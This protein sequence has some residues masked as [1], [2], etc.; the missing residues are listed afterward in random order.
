MWIHQVHPNTYLKHCFT[1]GPGRMLLQILAQAGDSSNLSTLAHL[2]AT[3]RISTAVQDMEKIR[4]EI[5]S[6]VNGPMLP[7]LRQ[8]GLDAEYLR[9]AALQV[10]RHF[11][12]AFLY[13]SGAIYVFQRHAGMYAQPWLLSE[14]V[15]LVQLSRRCLLMCLKAF[16]EY[17]KCISGV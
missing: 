11:Y 8:R 1:A 17:L 16:P 10:V 3:V 2:Q 13:P 6:A 9:L 5:I 12:L 7:Q 4:G 14:I 15:L